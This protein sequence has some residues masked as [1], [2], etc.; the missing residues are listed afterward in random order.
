[1]TDGVSGEP[2]VALPRA[3]ALR[4]VRPPGWRKGRGTPS[5]PVPATGMGGAVDAPSRDDAATEI[6]GMLQ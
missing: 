6:V 2:P 1:M 5:R 3:E 4:A